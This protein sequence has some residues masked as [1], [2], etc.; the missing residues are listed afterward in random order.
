MNSRATD[1]G[2]ARTKNASVTLPNSNLIV[3]GSGGSVILTEI[4][5]SYA[6]SV[7]TYFVGNVTWTNNFYSKPRRVAQIALTA[8]P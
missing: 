1:G 8:C 2:T 4:S 5:Y 6:S 7:S 3:A